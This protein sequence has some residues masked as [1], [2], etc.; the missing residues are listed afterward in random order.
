MP[1]SGWIP[2]PLSRPGEGEGHRGGGRLLSGPSCIPP[3]EIGRGPASAQRKLQA[4]APCY[5]LPGFPHT[6]AAARLLFPVSLGRGKRAPSPGKSLPRM[7]RGPGFP[8]FP[9]P[10]EG[11]DLPLPELPHRGLRGFSRLPLGV[12]CKQRKPGLHFEIYTLNGQGGT[13]FWRPAQACMSLFVKGR[14]CILR[15]SHNRKG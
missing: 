12:C 5:P 8:A 9:G 15:I 3:F 6:G 13:R 4:S 14:Q 7:L 1:W 10:A 2:C 11:T